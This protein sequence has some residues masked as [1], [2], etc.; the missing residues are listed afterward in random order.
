M[1]AVSG[2]ASRRAEEYVERD[3]GDRAVLQGRRGGV[4]IVRAEDLVLIRWKIERIEK[5]DLLQV[6]K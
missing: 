6:G 5:R 3:R 1:V 4:D 2:T